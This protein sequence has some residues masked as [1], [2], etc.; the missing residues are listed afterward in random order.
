MVG[1]GKKGKSQRKVWAAEDDPTWQPPLPGAAGAVYVVQSHPY[2]QQHRVEGMALR[3]CMLWRWRMAR[4]DTVRSVR[5][6]EIFWKMQVEE[7]L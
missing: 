5:A 6:L 3:P 2:L 1:L 4:W 7:G